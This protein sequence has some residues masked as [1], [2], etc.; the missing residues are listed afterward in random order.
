MREAT[1]IT[2][3]FCENIYLLV[4]FWVKIMSAA[5]KPKLFLLICVF[6]IPGL[7]AFVEWNS[8]KGAQLNWVEK[9]K[10][11][12]LIVLFQQPRGVLEMCKM[13]IASKTYREPLKVLWRVAGEKSKG[14]HAAMV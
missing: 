13:N 2:L 14:L 7:D 10:R 1:A 9:K 5:V 6:A 3:K 12:I 4:F 8:L 11:K